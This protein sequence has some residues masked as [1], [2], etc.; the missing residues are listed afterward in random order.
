MPQHHNTP[1]LSLKISMSENKCFQM[2]MM[3][4]YFCLIIQVPPPLKKRKVE[5]RRRIWK[6]KD[7][8]NTTR[9]SSDATVPN[10]ATED[11]TWNDPI[12]IFES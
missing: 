8:E 1:S 4:H 9:N 7:L 6:D 5:K 2:N 3:W 11:P 10:I 12:N